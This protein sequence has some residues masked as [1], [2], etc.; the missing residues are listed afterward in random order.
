MFLALPTH[1]LVTKRKWYG[2]FDFLFGYCARLFHRYAPFL[3]IFSVHKINSCISYRKVVIWF[4]LVS[5][6]S[7][8][9]QSTRRFLDWQHAQGY[10]PYHHPSH[11]R[12]HLICIILLLYIPLYYSVFIAIYCILKYVFLITSAPLHSL[13]FEICKM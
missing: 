8:L 3:N 7:T 11:P 12:S 6:S 1:F 4:N 10:T 5:L 9:D 2:L 13:P